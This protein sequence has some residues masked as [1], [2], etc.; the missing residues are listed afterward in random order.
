MTAQRGRPRSFDR[1]AALEQAALTFWEHGYE[2]TSISDLT[3]ALGIGAPSLYA[4]FGDKRALFFEAVDSYQATHGS[5]A[6]RALAEEPTATAAIARILREAAVEYTSTSHPRGCLVISAAQNCSPA[7]ADVEQAL[8]ATR[9]SNLKALEE[10]LRSD[11]NA[12]L[13]PAGTDARSL[14]LFAAAT[15]QGMSQQSRDGATR[16]DL[17]AI[18]ETAI[19]ALPA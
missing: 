6:A 14:A 7:S 8:R 3:T 1:A 12:G 18:A 4:A 17:R 10:R 9:N 2:T 11:V 19:R 5:F 15:T 13:L 16:A